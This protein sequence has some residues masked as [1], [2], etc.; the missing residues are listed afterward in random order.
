MKKYVLYIQAWR[1]FMFLV[2]LFLL[3]I[4]S[5]L[6]EVIQLQLQEYTKYK[7]EPP[8]YMTK[9]LAHTNRFF[10]VVKTWVRPFGL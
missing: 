2:G 8:A 1:T 9:E 7:G 6:N 4:T 5:D 3:R 10:S